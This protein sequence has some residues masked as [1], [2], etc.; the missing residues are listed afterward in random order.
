MFLGVTSRFASIL[1]QRET[2]R[3]G[4]TWGRTL[5]AD[6]P[7]NLAWK[8]PRCQRDQHIRND[9]KWPLRPLSLRRNDH[10]SLIRLDVSCRRRQLFRASAS[11]SARAGSPRIHLRQNCLHRRECQQ[12]RDPLILRIR[13]DFGKPLLQRRGGSAAGLGVRRRARNE[14]VRKAQ[15]SLPSRAR[16]ETTQALIEAQRC[17][18]KCPPQSII[19][20]AVS[21]E[22]DSS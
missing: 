14:F 8:G 9:L 10:R 6:C 11:G 19:I 4:V 7:A 5:R 22:G 12:V 20:R 2:K 16:I 3:R 21:R 18:A 1:S 17:V 13:N 15:I